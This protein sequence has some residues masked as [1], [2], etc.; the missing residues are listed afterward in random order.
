MYNVHVMKR[1]T[2]AQARARLSQA[3]DDAEAGSPVVIERRGVRFRIV[4]EPSPAARPR[5]APLVEILDP[6]VE[7]GQWTWAPASRGL[8][9]RS[10]PASSRLLK[11]P[12]T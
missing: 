6:A 8:R 12:A 7:R 11:K 3:L 4:R 5:R 10:R 9:F 1:Y 2:A